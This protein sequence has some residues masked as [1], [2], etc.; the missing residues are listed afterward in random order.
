M[1]ETGPAKIPWSKNCFL[2]SLDCFSTP[3]TAW[4]RMKNGHG[5]KKLLLYYGTTPESAWKEYHR[6]KKL[7]TVVGFWLT[8]NEV[9][10]PNY[11][12]QNVC[13]TLVLLLRHYKIKCKV[14]YLEQVYWRPFQKITTW[15][16]QIMQLPQNHIHTWVECFSSDVKS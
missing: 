2:L 6:G 12:C 9:Q 8:R 16:R 11:S 15:K 7:F 14:L 13:S 3:S 4:L 10:W 5:Y 1:N